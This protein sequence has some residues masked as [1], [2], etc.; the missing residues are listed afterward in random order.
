MLTPHLARALRCFLEGIGR[1]VWL[2]V[3]R[4]RAADGQVLDQ[5]DAWIRVM[6]IPAGIAVSC[7]GLIFIAQSKLTTLASRL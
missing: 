5:Q 6:A 2:P 1:R 3:T 4:I 7:L